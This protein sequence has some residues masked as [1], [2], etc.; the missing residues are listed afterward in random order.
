MENVRILL[1]LLC[2]CRLFAVMLVCFECRRGNCRIWQTVPVTVHL[3][4]RCWMISCVIVTGLVLV[5]VN[6]AV[7]CLLL[8]TYFCTVLVYTW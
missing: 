8:I 7:S 5:L 2:L 6:N 4:W 3:S 1:L